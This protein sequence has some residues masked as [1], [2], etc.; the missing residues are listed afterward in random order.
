MLIKKNISPVVIIPI[1]RDELQADEK[2]SLEFAKKNLS[3]YPIILCA[4]DGLEILNKELAACHTIR[5]PAHFFTSVNSYSRLLMSHEF[6]RRLSRWS[7]VL[8]YQLDCLVFRDALQEWCRNDWDYIAAPW[9]H[10]F[11]DDTS[12]G[13]WRVGNGGFSLRKI[14]SHLRVLSKQAYVGSIYPENGGRPWE[15]RSLQEDLGIYESKFPDVWQR[16]KYRKYINTIENESKGYLLNEDLFWSLEAPKIDSS[17]K[18]CPAEEALPFAFEMSPEWCFQKNNMKLPFGC[19]AWARYDREFWE[20]MISKIN[21]K[22][23]LH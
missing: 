5:F 11:L 13:L 4:P 18:V 21:L 6:Y 12:D 20:S 3:D 14:S 22:E 1:Y 8:I 23:P 7:H 10:K 17:F 2:I 16:I 9:F 15:P 19:H